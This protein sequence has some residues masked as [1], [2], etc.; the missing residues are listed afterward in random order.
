MIQIND[1]YISVNGDRLIIDAETDDLETII[2]H[3]YIDTQD[4]YLTTGPSD[5]RVYD[6]EVVIDDAKDE[7]N[8]TTDDDKVRKLRIEIPQENICASLRNNFFII[9]LEDGNEEIVLS[10]AMWMRP[11]FNNFLHW[12]REINNECELPKNYIYLFLQ[13]QAFITSVRTCNIMEAIKIYNKYFHGLKAI[14]TNFK[15]CGCRR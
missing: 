13:Y 9:Y 14:G 10:T 12:I 2:S 8:S 7:C 11:L 3:I 1:T 6:H 4:S 5:D 15:G